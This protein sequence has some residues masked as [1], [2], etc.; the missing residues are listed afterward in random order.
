MHISLIRTTTREGDVREFVFETPHAFSWQAGQYLHYTLAHD[1][2]ERGAE[3]WF[4]ISSAPSEHELRI[5]THIDTQRGS[6]FKRALCALQPGD[7]IQIGEP[8]GDFTLQDPSRHYVFIAGGIGITPIRSILVEAAAQHIPLQA[9][10]LYA[11][12]N[13]D[14][15]FRDEL[16]NLKDT[17]EHVEVEYIVEPRRLD[18]TLLRDTLATHPHPLVY[19]SGPEGMVRALAVRVEKLGIASQDIKVDDFPGYE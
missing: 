13:E 10:L 12:R 4:T 17:L 6:S 18:D 14:I 19:I 1:A 16:E 7:T 15:P 11:S 5:T 8:E 2:D 9:T 3:R